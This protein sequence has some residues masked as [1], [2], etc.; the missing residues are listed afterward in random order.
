MHRECV[1]N[2]CLPFLDVFVP[3][4]FKRLPTTIEWSRFRKYARRVRTLRECGTLEEMS[5]EVFSVMQSRTINDL[6]LPNM[7]TLYLLG[8]ERAFIPFISL[9]L[10]PRITSIF[11]LFSASDHSNATIASTVTTLPTLCPNLQ[12]IN[13]PYLPRNPMITAA[14]SE[15]VLAT[16]RNTLQKFDVG[17]LLTKEASDMVYKLPNLRILRVMIG[18][19]ASFPSVSLSNLTNLEIICNDESDWPRLFHGA[20]FGKL[21][22][23]QFFPESEEIGD[24]L[25]AFER[26]A[27]SIQNT[28]STFQ[29]SPECAWNPNYSSLLR[30]TQL[31]DLDIGFSCE[32]G[33][34]SE[35]DDDIVIDI[36]R[37]MPKLQALKLGNEPCREFTAGVTAKGLVALTLHCPDLWHLRVHFQVAS[38]SA[39]PVNPGITQNAEPTGSRTD[40]GLMQ[41]VA[42]EI[43]MPD[44]SVLTVGLALLQIFPRIMSIEYIDEGWGKVEAAIHLY[45]RIV[46]CS[47]KHSL[48]TSWGDFNDTSIE[49]TLEA[50]S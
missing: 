46:G 8:I 14:I 6:F 28:L 50:G 42:G 33:C 23:V 9:F 3:K 18:R 12:A 16:D 1:S 19:G 27:S 22:T 38:L 40:C 30:F 24:F 43:P 17:S 34:F 13:L 37:V 47:S 10:S 20:T 44:E 11:L 32:D 49:A 48:T 31:V 41:L 36:S 21:E 35:V 26:V 5:S 25:E 45:R 29:V 15:M 4:S 2:A 7:N 39:P